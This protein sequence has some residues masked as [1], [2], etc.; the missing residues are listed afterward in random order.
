MP[1]LTFVVNGVEPLLHAASPHLVFKLALGNAVAEQEIHAITLRCQIRLEPGRRSY[2]ATEK[3]KL[4][5]L[6]GAPERWG[7]TVRGMLW[8]HCQVTVPPFTGS[9]RVDMPVPCTFDFNIAA[10]KYFAA[11]EDGA[12]PLTFLFSGTIFYATSEGT[13]QIA[14]ISWE[15]EAAFS[16]PVRAWQDMMDHYYPNTSWLQ[17]RRDVFDRLYQYKVNQGIP[18]WE[19]LLTTLLDQLP[20]KP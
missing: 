8:T 20:K 3:A 18:T 4:R 10:T 1:D 17:L 6:F 19:Q 5:D 15:K 12:A 2:T 13:L 9:A 16:L 7:Q 14:Q 11:L